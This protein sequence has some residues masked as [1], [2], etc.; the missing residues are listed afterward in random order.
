MPCSVRLVPSYYSLRIVELNLDHPWKTCA[1]PS[2]SRRLWGSHRYAKGP[3]SLTLLWSSEHALTLH[4]P[5]PV[6]VG[7]L[8]FALHRHASF[9]EPPDIMALHMRAFTTGLPSQHILPDHDDTG[10]PAW[11]AAQRLSQQLHGLQ[12]WASVRLLYGLHGAPEYVSTDRHSG[13][14]AACRWWTRC[15]RCLVGRRTPQMTRPLTQM[16]HRTAE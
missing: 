4:K 9:G 12:W 15:T 5:T 16:T 6:Q 7:C 1:V 13:K 3:G 14:P 11:C 2:T 8:G 10:P